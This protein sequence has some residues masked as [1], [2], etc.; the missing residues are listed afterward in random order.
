MSYPPRNPEL[1]WAKPLSIDLLLKVLNVTFLHPF[2]GWM[3]PLCLRAQAKPWSDPAMRMAIGWASF[4]TLFFFLGV[5]NRQL[6]YTKPR[7]VD[8]SEEVIV[9]TGGASGLGLLVA[10]VYGMR[11]ASVA[12]LDVQELESGEARGV[13]MYKC[14][15]GNPDQVKK[16]AIE[17]ERDLGTPTILINNAGIANGKRLL[18]L[19]IEDIERTMRVNLLSQFYTI[20][21]FLP[22]MVRSKQG[23][24]VTISSV[25]GQIGASHLTDY[26]AS[27]AAITALHKSLRAELRS[28]PEIKTILVSPGQLTTPMFNGVVTPSSFFGPVLEPVD[29]AREIIAAIDSGS[30]ADLAL[31]LYA[32][33]IDWMNVVPVGVHAVL[34]KLSGVDKAMEGFIGRN[35]SSNEKVESLI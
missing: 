4:L 10:E 15:V 5:L 28:T 21:A 17:I 29:V 7:E 6:A 18:D 14:D 2:V 33:W 16:A 8:F 11:G 35:G 24:I 27:K 22:G 19:S 3:I 20:K 13:S 26:A 30:S 12:V 31:P 9:I 1:S 34:R 25:L 32:R 23:T